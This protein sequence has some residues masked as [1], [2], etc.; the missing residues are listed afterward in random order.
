M[1]NKIVALLVLILLSHCLAQAPVFASSTVLGHFDGY[2]GI[3]AKNLRTGQ[4]IELNQDEVFP[5][6]STSKL[7]VALAVYKYLYPL[8]PAEVKAEYAF[9]D[10]Y[11]DPQKSATLK[12]ALANTIFR[13]ELPRY[14]PGTVMHKIGQLDDILCD[15]G[16]VDDGEDQV[17]ISIYTRTDRSED[18]A[19]DY[20]AKTA[21]TL[22]TALKSP[23]AAD[24]HSNHS[25]LR[26]LRTVA[27]NFACM[28]K[29]VGG[30]SNF[31]YKSK[32]PNYSRRVACFSSG[33]ASPH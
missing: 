27:A 8:A 31:T 15:V 25:F 3:Y 4:T 19:S 33:R 1:K 2:V 7:A 18:Y 14:L 29:N 30:Y 10:T 11:L 28:L 23:A 32:R 6:A 21:S 20:I 22:Y 13:D 5:T 12:E 17:L 16:I 26:F 9:R 24:D